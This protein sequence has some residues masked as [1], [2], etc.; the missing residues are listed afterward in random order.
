MYNG[1]VQLLVKLKFSGVVCVERSDLGSPFGRA[2]CPVWGRLRGRRTIEMHLFP[3]TVPSQS[4]CSADSSPKGRAKGT[5]APVQKI[6][7]YR[8]DASS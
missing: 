7:F 4:A 3:T 1:F 5:A 2:V 6:T 8:R